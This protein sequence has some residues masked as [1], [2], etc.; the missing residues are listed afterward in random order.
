MIIL[1]V[2]ERSVRLFGNIEG[3]RGYLGDKDSETYSNQKKK[4][5]DVKGER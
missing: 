3:C 1:S 2:G 4:S 5:I